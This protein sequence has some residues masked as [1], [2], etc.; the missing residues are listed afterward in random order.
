MFLC[1]VRRIGHVLA[2]KV[3]RCDFVSGLATTSCFEH[4][5]QSVACLC[6]L[7]H[8]ISLWKHVPG[9]I[10]MTQTQR[11]P[12]QSFPTGSGWSR[13][14]V[15][16]HGYWVSSRASTSLTKLL[17]SIRR[18]SYPEK[19]NS[20]LSRALPTSLCVWECIWCALKCPSTHLLLIVLTMTLGTLMRLC[21]VEE[22]WCCQIIGCVWW[23]YGTLTWLHLSYV[24][25]Q[26]LLWLNPFVISYL[27]PWGLKYEITKDEL[28]ILNFLGW[29]SLIPSHCGDFR[30]WGL[31]NENKMHPHDVWCSL[32]NRSSEFSA[33]MAGPKGNIASRTTITGRFC[34]LV[35]PPSTPSRFYHLGAWPTKVDASTSVSILADPNLTFFRGH[36]FCITPSLR[37]TDIVGN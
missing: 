35:E 29:W 34:Y 22:K 37:N 14:R 6:T 2:S 18:T 4:H 16:H 9:W 26:L 13:A 21:S 10:P 15:L 30:L 3:S 33:T 24:N 8:W 7:L 32:S 12:L 20:Y 23:R 28:M 31:K 36:S 17:A 19:R 11:K 5:P 27:R 25:M 1:L